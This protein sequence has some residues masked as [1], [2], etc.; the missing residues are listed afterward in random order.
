MWSCPPSA[1]K[2]IMGETGKIAI[3]LAEDND[4]HAWLL[5]DFFKQAGIANELIRFKDGQE[6]WEFVSGRAPGR[7]APADY[8]LL[9]DICMPRMD[10]IELLKRIKQDPRLKVMPVIMINNDDNPKEISFCSEL[11]CG[12]YLNKPLDHESFAR[13]LKR[14]GLGMTIFD[15]QDKAQ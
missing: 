8:L 7:A 5:T 12:G 4:G 10:G 15:K 3:L 1:A 14:L 13:A 11:G 6:V 9:L 2:T